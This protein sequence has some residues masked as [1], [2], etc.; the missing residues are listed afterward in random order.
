MQ[1][2]VMVIARRELASYFDSPIAYIVIATFL[3]TAGWMFFSTLF[4]MGRADMRSFFA[5][6]PFSPSM[7]LVILV[8]AV[9][10]RLIAEEKKTG[11]F[12]L[13]TTMPVRDSEIVMGKFLAAFALLASALSPTLL[14]AVT[15]ASMGQLDWGPVIAGYAGFLL[16][17]MSLLSIGMWCSAI[18]DKQ[19]VAFI[20]SFIVSAALYFMYWLQF[21]MPASLAPLVEFLSVSAHLDNMARGVIDSRDVLFYGTLTAAGLM[22]TTRSLTQQHA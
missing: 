11:T 3:L 17:S 13:L 22:M 1:R 9:T 19:I 5:P 8:P 14:Y 6:A 16:F 18:T 7:L 12:E 4:L 2:K 21:F 10:M 20:I 15:V